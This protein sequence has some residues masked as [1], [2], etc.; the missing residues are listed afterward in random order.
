MLSF[1]SLPLLPPPTQHCNPGTRQSSGTPALLHPIHTPH[2]ST[3]SYVFQHSSPP[4][5]PLQLLWHACSGHHLVFLNSLLILAPPPVLPLQLPALK[6]EQAF[7]STLV[8]IP[9]ACCSSQR[10]ASPPSFSSSKAP[11]KALPSSPLRLFNSSSPFR[12]QLPRGSHPSP[13][14]QA[15]STAPLHSPITAL[16]FY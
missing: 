7:Q 10:P 3:G 2:L 4:S 5:S 8:I 13:P 12:T 16:G 11:R 14:L 1:L 6:L 15:D 9:C